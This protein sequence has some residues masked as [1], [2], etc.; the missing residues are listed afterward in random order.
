[1]LANITLAH[2]AVAYYM[3][4][5]DGS[6]SKDEKRL[7][8]AEVK[9]LIQ[10]GSF[11]DS[12]IIEVKKIKA[13]KKMDF[14]K[15]REYL[16]KIDVE[17]VEKLLDVAYSIADV[18]GEITVSETKALNLLGNYVLEKENAIDDDAVSRED[19]VFE[20]EVEKAVNEY[21]LRM[22]L[23]DSTFEQRVKLNKKEVSLLM[24]A[25]CLHCLRIYGVNYFTEIEQATKGKKEK[26][27]HK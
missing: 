2:I 18:N 10:E 27:L 26:F 20:E 16:D 13:D 9:R 19:V 17:A 5:I 23:L 24:F 15:V 1:M 4:R 25:T 3:A 11:N 8:D 7:L 12:F 22:K 6:I 21:T 14:I